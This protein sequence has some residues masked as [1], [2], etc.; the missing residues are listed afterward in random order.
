V[1][2]AAPPPRITVAAPR[3]QR[4]FDSQPL[5]ARVGCDRPCDLRVTL[6]G[7]GEDGAEALSLTHART[8]SVKLP[9]FS[10]A[11][12]TLARRRRHVRVRATAP[13]GRE[14]VRAART[15]LILRRAPLPVPRIIALRAVRRG[16]VIMVSWRTEFPA[17]RAVFAV[18]GQRQRRLVPDTFTEPPSFAVRRGRGRTHF[19]ARLRPERPERVRWVGVYAYSRDAARGHRAAVRV[20]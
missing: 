8:I 14:V 12:R 20:R 13:N 17:R 3:R 15:V 11:R 1:P 4:L 9:H 5:R 16:G 18:I 7:V 6:S 2:A 10:D 19:R